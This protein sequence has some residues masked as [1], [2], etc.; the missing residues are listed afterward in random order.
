MLGTTQLRYFRAENGLMLLS[1]C[2]VGATELW[3][4]PYLIDYLT[5]VQ[6]TEYAP[7]GT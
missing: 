5:S 3:S 4:T 7:I 6:S 2:V 1:D